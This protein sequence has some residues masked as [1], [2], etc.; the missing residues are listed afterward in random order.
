MYVVN[1]YLC[2]GL[3]V[4]ST[5]KCFTSTNC[6]LLVFSI[7][8]GRRCLL[9][10]IDWKETGWRVSVLWEHLRDTHKVKI[11]RQQTSTSF[12]HSSH[13]LSVSFLSQQAYLVFSLTTHVLSAALGTRLL[14]SELHTFGEESLLFLLLIVRCGIVAQTQRGQLSH[15][16]VTLVQWGVYTCTTTDLWVGH[17]IGQ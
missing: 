6:Y 8:S 11:T 14:K 1:L 10:V 13:S 15:W 9:I 5:S 16:L 7:V 3:H 4:K 2:H 17:L 12:S